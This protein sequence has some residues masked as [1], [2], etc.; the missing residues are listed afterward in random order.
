V[1]WL[2]TSVV[3]VLAVT[4]ALAG[5]GAR[6]AGAQPRS[7]ETGPE[8]AITQRIAVW[9]F[10][11]LGIEPELVARLETLFRMELDRLAKQPMPSRREV[12][13]AVTA[14]QRECT[15][16]EKC[17]GAIGKKLGVDVVVTGTVGALGDSYVLNIKAVEAATAKQLT[18]IQSDPLRG[19]PDDLIEG[20]RVAAYK[21]LAPA[22][23]HGSIQ[24][25][26]DLVGAAVELD[27]KTIGKTPLPQL[28][29]IPKQQ[30]GK[31][32]LRVQAQGYAPF[33]EDVEVRFQKVSQVVVRLL[34]SDQVIGTGRVERLTR[35]PF[36]TK[37][38]FIVGVGVAAAAI[39]TYA[40]WRAGTVDCVRIKPG[41]MEQEGC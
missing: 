12:E 30:L 22:Q 26:S 41:T 33:E 24:I 16:E 15:G 34:P 31:H 2:T 3:L 27:G 38:W 5:A 19:T 29:V 6:S 28:G 7:T 39:G 20:V 17:L 32:R 4:A 25:Q 23:L 35:R 10:D 1:R 18:R 40:G 37:T 11:A 8:Q 14:D 9:R 21:L 36:Y 13:R